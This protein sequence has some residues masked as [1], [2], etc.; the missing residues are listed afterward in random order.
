V[1]QAH[2]AARVTFTNRSGAA[3]TRDRF[4][5]TLSS[6]ELGVPWSLRR[7]PLPFDIAD[8]A[9]VTL[10]FE[11]IEPEVP[12]AADCVGGNTPVRFVRQSAPPST[13]DPGQGFDGRTTFANCSMGVWVGP[14][15]STP[16]SQAPRSPRGECWRRLLGR[17]LVF[18]L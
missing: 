3:W 11:L 14:T 1:L 12:K 17:G 16:R 9:E 8:G 15:G 4:A 13:V 6:P 18:L 10:R 5:L 2:V 7:V